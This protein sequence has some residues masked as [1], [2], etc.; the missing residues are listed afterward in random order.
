MYRKWSDQ[1]SSYVYERAVMDASEGKSMMQYPMKKM[2]TYRV[3]SCSLSSTAVNPS[4]QT[5]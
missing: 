2:A 5:W 1:P 4:L 3:M